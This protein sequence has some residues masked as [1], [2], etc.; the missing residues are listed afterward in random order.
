[1]SYLQFMTKE[2]KLIWLYLYIC[3][4]HDTELCLHCQRM[5]NN[6]APK[7]SDAELIT[8]YLFAII[9]QKSLTI[10]S[11]HR[12]ISRY[13][14]SWFPELPSYQK[15]AFRL[16]R[17]S[18]VFPALVERVC[19][20]ASNAGVYQQIS[21]VDSLPIIIAGPKRTQSAKVAPSLCD[22]SYCAS[23]GLWYYGVKLHLLAWCRPASLPFPEYA[24]LTPASEHD[25]TAFKRIANRLNEREIYADKAYFDRELKKSLE[26]HNNTRLNTSIRM[27]R[28]QKLEHSDDKLFSSI[29]S[30]I[31]Q[32]LESLFHWI[33]EKTGIQNASKVRSEIGLNIHVFGKLAAAMIMLTFRFLN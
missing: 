1:M 14:Q 11:I 12:F 10:K 29:V 2:E 4:A 16:N 7:F 20:A 3:E 8:T 21:L 18:E 6:Y 27:V 26:N 17:L 30:K 13:W 24:G 28:C 33:N 25:L 5:S 22:K 19:R 9:E 15:Y 31:R 23:K 32:P